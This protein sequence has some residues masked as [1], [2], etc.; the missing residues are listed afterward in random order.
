MVS[1]KI[2][3]I[4]DSKVIRMKIKDMLAQNDFDILE[5]KDGQEGYEM[6]LNENLDLIILDF[7][8]PKMS[9]YEL[10]R[11]IQKQER[12]RNIPLIIMSGRKEEVVEKLS[13]PFEDFTFIQKPFDEKRLAEAISGA[14]DKNKTQ[15]LSPTLQELIIRVDQLQL[16]I[17]AVKQ[18][19]NKLIN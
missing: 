11:E 7:I 9:G 5:A 1:R 8:L 15:A 19:L 12:L 3:V 14:I 2:I 17:D 18:Q 16:E 10:Y 4:D 13:E 6:I